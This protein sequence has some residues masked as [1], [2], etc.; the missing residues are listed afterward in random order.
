MLL[1]H[2]I[3]A[4]SVALAAAPEV[5]LGKRAEALEGRLMAPCCMTNT[6]AVHE[7]GASYRIRAE[8]REMLAAG[9]TDREIL[10]HYVAEYGPQILA[11]P[12]ARGFNLT[13]YLFPL[14]FLITGAAILWAAMR[15]WKGPSQAATG[16]SPPPPLD[17]VYA[18]RLDRELRQLD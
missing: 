12:E 14:V 11:I 18:R 8:I 17:P 15:R 2:L 5:D 9:K 3:L 13:A 16:T 7:S 1:A 4:G 10:D 6:V